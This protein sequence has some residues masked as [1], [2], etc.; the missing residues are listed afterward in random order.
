MSRKHIEYIVKNLGRADLSLAEEGID[1][2]QVIALD[3]AYEF[4]PEDSYCPVSAF[5]AA[6]SGAGCGVFAT[7]EGKAYIVGDNGMCA[8]YYSL[9][10]PATPK[11]H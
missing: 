5:P 1:E 6:I 3:P 9:T 4:D 10:L 11:E 8:F 2:Q 7:S